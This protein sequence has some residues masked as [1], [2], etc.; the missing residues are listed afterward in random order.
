MM[1]NEFLCG[2]HNIKDL[3]P[4]AQD[5]PILKENINKKIDCFLSNS[6][7]FGGTNGSIIIRRA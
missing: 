6:F 2:S 7:G 3:D 5:F 1:E 4:A